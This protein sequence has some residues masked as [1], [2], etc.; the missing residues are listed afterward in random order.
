MILANNPNH[1]FVG[2]HCAVLAESYLYRLDPFIFQVT[3]TIGLRW[4]GVAYIAG[5]L[6]A[7]LALRWMSRVKFS[8]LQTDRAGDLV[9][10]CVLG[11]LIGGRLGYGLFYD[12]SVFISFT[13]DFPWWEAISIHHGGMSSHGGILGVLATFV[14][15][16]RKNKISQLHL[17]D[18]GS[19]CTIPGL[20]YGRLAN[21]INGELWGRALPKETQPNPPWWSVKYP[22][23]ITDVWTADPARYAEQLAAVD[24]L[25]TKIIGGD[26]FHANVVKEIY[27]GNEEVIQTIQP[28]LTAFHPSQLF[29]AIAEGPV[30]LAA[31]VI[32]WWRPRKPGVVSGWFLI[33][34]GLMR[35]CTEAYRQPDSGVEL[36]AGLSRGQLLSVFMVVFGSAMVMIC[37]KRESEKFGGFCA[38]GT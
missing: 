13:S 28:L 1:H 35:I 26:T 25:Q 5:F 7:W 24:T 12:P 17:F 11:V 14:V 37:T 6:T 31:L 9:F 36:I 29:Q 33:L 38:L 15:W 16:G 10:A 34:Y 2:Y 19:V 18:I 3:E 21:F 30:L 20:F 32:V 27:A 22:S 8:S 4:Y 23:E